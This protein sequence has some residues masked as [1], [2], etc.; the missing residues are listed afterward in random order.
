MSQKHTLEHVRKELYIPVLFDRASEVAWL[1]AGKRD[2]RD[3]AR[4]K[5]KDLLRERSPEPLQKDAQLKL[6]EIVKEAEMELVKTGAGT[7]GPT[8][9]HQPPT[10]PKT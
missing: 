3:V 1:K 4:A 2:I 7:A 6:R 5:C 8:L 10:R 9:H